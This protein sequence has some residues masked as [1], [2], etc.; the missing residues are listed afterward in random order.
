VECI[1]LA[2]HVGERFDGVVVDR[3]QHGVVVQM[4]RPAIVAPM[5]ADAVLGE[6]VEVTVVSVD[7]AARRIE[8]APAT[9][10]PT[11]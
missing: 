6:S 5:A 2:S 8:L 11:S 7:V 1:V 3:N 9:P 4:R 10:T